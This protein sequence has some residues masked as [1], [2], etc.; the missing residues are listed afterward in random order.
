MILSFQNQQ[1][2]IGPGSVSNQVME[3]KVRS[4]YDIFDKRRKTF[5]AIQADKDDMAQLKELEAE[6]KNR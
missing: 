3:T 2:L 5:D 1:V 4:V 6:L